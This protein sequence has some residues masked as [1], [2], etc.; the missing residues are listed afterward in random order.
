MLSPMNPA[1]RGSLRTLNPSRVQPTSVPLGD[2]SFAEGP[3][4]SEGRVYFTDQPKNRVLAWDVTRP[5]AAPTELGLRVR[6][7][8]MA[9]D[10]RGA[11]LVCA[12]G[13]GSLIRYHP[14]SGRIEAL[15]RGYKGARFNGPNDV[16][17][18]P[19]GDIYFTDPFF[20]R[21]WNP[22]PT[23]A[24]ARV[25]CLKRDGELRVFDETLH[26]PNGIAGTPDGRT[27]YVAE[28]V[29][30]AG[31]LSPVT[32]RYDLR[33]DGGGYEKKRV[34]VRRGSD[35]MT[36]DRRGRVYLTGGDRVEVF[37]PRGASVA[38]IPTGPGWTSNVALV[39]EGEESLLITKEGRV[40]TAP[41]PS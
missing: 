9:A 22:R 10:T 26:M 39:G 8:G 41:T 23:Q 32:Y 13:S 21:D 17:R 27:L 3:V 33:P 34:F 2:G 19:G 36:V 15:S 1:T 25:Y 40:M 29:F 35:G 12:E 6:A 37:S 31:G 7:N 14:A 11:L 30:L 18:A 24:R 16:W 4:W 20:P 38:R 5:S 28:N